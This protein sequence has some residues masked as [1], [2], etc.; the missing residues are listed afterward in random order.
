MEISHKQHVTTLLNA[1]GF[2]LFV[3][4]TKDWSSSGGAGMGVVSKTA[5]CAATLL[6]S[7][8]TLANLNSEPA[9]ARFLRLR[10]AA[11]HGAQWFVLMI[12]ALDVPLPSASAAIWLGCSALFGLFVVRL[13]KPTNAGAVA[14]ATGFALYAPLLWWVLAATFVLLPVISDRA[15]VLFMLILTLGVAAPAP[16]TWSALRW[17]EWAMAALSVIAVLTGLFTAP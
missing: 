6:Y 13:S 5:F 10:G 17:P 3:W 14:A 16:L 2:C 1:L 4:L 15:Y 8:P 7:A 12:V 11:M 9:D